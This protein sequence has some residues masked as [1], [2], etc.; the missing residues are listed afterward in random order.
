MTR[1]GCSAP[2]GKAQA[3]KQSRL[4]EPLPGDPLL[5][6]PRSVR[7]G[8]GATGSSFGQ[9]RGPDPDQVPSPTRSFRLAGHPDRS[10]FLARCSRANRLYGL[11]SFAVVGREVNVFCGQIDVGNG[12]SPMIDDAALGRLQTDGRSVARTPR[13]TWPVCHSPPASSS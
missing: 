7:V 9:Q 2:R 8:P 12:S 5:M 4:A 6:R 13:C 11:D 10:Q 1:L 3:R